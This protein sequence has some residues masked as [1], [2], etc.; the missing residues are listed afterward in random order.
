MENRLGTTS[1]MYAGRRGRCQY[2]A[3]WEFDIPVVTWT[4]VVMGLGDA[5]KLM[6]G[7][8]D[9]DSPAVDVAGLV[10][11]EVEERID[12]QAWLHD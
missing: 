5:P 9:V 1:K 7:Q 4:A 8:I 2:V 10:R 11:R 6:V 3:H 12:L